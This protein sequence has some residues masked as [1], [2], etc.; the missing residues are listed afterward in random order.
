MPDKITKKCPNCGIDKDISDYHSSKSS[1]SKLKIQPYCKD[2]GVTKQREWIKNNP[3]LYALQKLRQR[4]K[5]F[6][7]TVDKF[8]EL[9]VLQ[10]G[11]CAIC[12]TVL[13][14]LQTSRLSVDHDHKCCPGTYSCGECIRGLLCTNCNSGL[15]HFKDNPNLLTSAINYL[16]G[17]IS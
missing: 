6:N 9:L 2:C 10:G 14:S 17:A 3:D 1:K 7:I 11:G 16:G 8:N 15:G 13:N 4:L 5:R 12:G